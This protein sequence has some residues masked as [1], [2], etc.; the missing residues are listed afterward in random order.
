M[1]PVR[2]AC[3]DRL[4]SGGHFFVRRCD[5]CGF[6]F[7]DPLPDPSEMPRFYASDEYAP[8]AE[9]PRNIVERIGRFV[10]PLRMSRKHAFIR[11]LTGGKAGKSLDYGS[12]RGDFLRTM[13]AAGWTAIGVEPDARGREYAASQGLDARDLD[14]VAQFRDGSFDLVTLWHVLEHVH[15]PVA[16]LRECH[17]LLRPGGYCVI[18]VPNADCPSIQRYAERWFAWDVPRHISHFTV[19]TLQQCA[20]QAGLSFSS[21]HPTLTDPFY[22]C[23][24]SEQQ[25]GRFAV[26][27]IWP[28]IAC[29]YRGFR[30]PMLGSAIT[31][32]F[33]KEAA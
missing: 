30:S 7:T 17:R 23:M 20:S 14:A 2:Y 13:K 12:G 3:D 24:R 25:R 29:A 31:C 1:C 4:G 27:G 19:P 9:Q 8:L 5:D 26:S 28:G 33:S 32:V 11:R 21:V 10:T 15:D 18:E 22:I 16:V 6:G